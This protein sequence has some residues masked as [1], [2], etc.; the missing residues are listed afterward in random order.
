ML[1]EHPL[2]GGK[3]RFTLSSVECLRGFLGFVVLWFFLFFIG[4]YRLHMCIY[5]IEPLSAQVYKP[6]TV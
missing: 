5:V 1:R 3:A 4:L 6:V 2:G